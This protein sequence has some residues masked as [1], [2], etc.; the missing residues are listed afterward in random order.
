ML[1]FEMF[2]YITLSASGIRAQG[3]LEHPTGVYSFVMASGALG[4]QVPPVTD[5]TLVH[6]PA[7]DVHL[8]VGTAP[9]LQ[10]YRGIQFF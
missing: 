1:G 3:A 9:R 8:H 10:R 4:G 5:Q 7:I 2:H 6:V